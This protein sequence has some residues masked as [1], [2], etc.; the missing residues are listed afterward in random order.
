[1][2]EEKGLIRSVE[3]ACLHTAADVVAHGYEASSLMC[4]SKSTG[5]VSFLGQMQSHAIHDRSCTIMYK[6]QLQR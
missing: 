4:Y 2:T 6:Q 1:M 5:M 3:I